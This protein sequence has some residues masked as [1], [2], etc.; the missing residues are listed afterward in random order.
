MDA[1]ED[2]PF[3][4]LKTVWATRGLSASDIR[5]R[6]DGT[7]MGSDRALQAGTDTVLA[8]ETVPAPFDAEL[9]DRKI[10]PGAM[11][12]KGGMGIVRVAAQSTM[13][14]EV[15]LKHVRPDVGVREAAAAILKEAWVGGRLEHPNLVPVYDVVRMDDAPG[16]LMKRISGATWTELIHDESKH[17]R[18][19]IRD[20]LAW[21]LQ[22]FMQVSNAIAFAHARGILHLDLKPANVMIG[23]FGE[24]YVLDWGLAVRVREDGPEW[25]SLASEIRGVSGTPGYMAPELASADGPSIGEHTDV[26]LLGAILHEIITRRALHDA[27][28]VMAALVSAYESL[29]QTYPASVPDELVAIIHRATHRE[30]SERFEGVAE[31]RDAVEAFLEHR[32]SIR[33]CDR[34]GEQLDALD[35]IEPGASEVEREAQVQRLFGG[36]RT[37]LD[38]AAEGWADNPRLPDLEDRLSTLMVEHALASGRPDLAKAYLESFERAPKELKKRVHRALREAEIE[39]ARVAQL[40]KMHKELDLS[41]SRQARSRV[42][43]ILGFMWLVNNVG[44]GIMVDRGWHVLTYLDLILF[45]GLI[46]ACA[47]AVGWAQRDVYFANKVNARFQGTLIFTGFAV[48]LLWFAGMSVGFPVL[49]GLQFSAFAYL[50]CFGVLAIFVERRLVG[51]AVAMLAAVVVDMFWPDGVLYTLG[52]GGMLAAIQIWWVWRTE[53]EQEE[54]DAGLDLS[55][56]RL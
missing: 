46:L 33:L 41:H 29:P 1:A 11:L 18:Y 3:D 25:L 45:A 52:V 56:T 9:P 28:G 40:E 6:P 32:D 44:M 17:E 23:E 24:V 22:V 10:V 8:N 26:Y 54:Q 35:R 2:Q 31:L 5:E 16:M 38:Q 39:Q 53:P 14:R 20:P 36:T 13:R 51:A 21:H 7:L 50:L 12:G 43:L 19:R 47:I 15:A 30:P 4:S 34:A 55:V 48:L 42:A 27:G 49:L 37:A